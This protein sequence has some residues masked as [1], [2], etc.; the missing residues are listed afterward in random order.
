[1]IKKHSD[2]YLFS[3]WFDLNV[4]HQIFTVTLPFPRA[5]VFPTDVFKIHLQ[6]NFI[7][8]SVYSRPSFKLFRGREKLMERGRV[9]PRARELR[10]CTCTRLRRRKKEGANRLVRNQLSA[11]SRVSAFSRSS[12]ELS[13]CSSLRR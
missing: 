6:W 4:N 8:C 3:R 1:M 12:S 5:I 13:R 10:G 9:N 2:I 7:P 11:F